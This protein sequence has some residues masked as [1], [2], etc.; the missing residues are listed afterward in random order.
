MQ[1]KTGEKVLTKLIAKV[2]ENPYCPQAYYE[3]GSFL[4]ELKNYVQAEELFKRALNVFEKEPQKQ[5]ILHYGLGNVFYASELYPQAIQE[6]QY[7]TDKN[8][9]AQAYMMLA[10]TY[11]ATKNYQQALAFALTASNTSTQ[12]LDAYKLMADCFLALGDFD[13]AQKYYHQVLSQKVDDVHANFYCGVCATVLG[14]DGQEYFT[15][16]KQ[17]DLKYYEKMHERLADIQNLLNT[18]K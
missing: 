7:I 18:K 11:Y 14:Q 5:E 12:A 6:F 16:V 17:K 2:D 1:K 3:L 15:K 8:L 4:V 13:Q 9:K 10:Q